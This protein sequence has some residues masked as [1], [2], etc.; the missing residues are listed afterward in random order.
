VKEKAVEQAIRI[1]GDKY[2]SVSATVRTIAEIT[3]EY[4]IVI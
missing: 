2:C 4:V 1:S 3:T